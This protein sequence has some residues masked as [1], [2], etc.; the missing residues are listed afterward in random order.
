M[1]LNYL[2]NPLIILSIFIIVYYYNVK[3]TLIQ[4]Y[5]VK[6]YNSMREASKHI[7]TT[8]PTESLENNDSLISIIPF[9]L[10]MVTK[11]IFKQNVAWF[12]MFISISVQVVHSQIGFEFTRLVTSCYKIAQAIWQCQIWVHFDMNGQ[13]W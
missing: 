10:L 11:M 6:Y 5:N 3:Y 13:T 9:H 4:P 2:L 12:F 7:S 8:N 1:K